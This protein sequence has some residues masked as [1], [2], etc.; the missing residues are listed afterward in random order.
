[1][2]LFD[3]HLCLLAFDCCTKQI[4]LFLIAKLSIYANKCII[5][6][7]DGAYMLERLIY[8]HVSILLTDAFVM[9]WKPQL[10][11]LMTSL[12]IWLFFLRFRWQPHLVIC[13]FIRI[14]FPWY[15]CNET[16]VSYDV[17]HEPRRDSYFFTSQFKSCPFSFVFYLGNPSISA[18]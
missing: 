16:Y 11:S 3:V 8:V 12:V 1:M 4:Y 15:M 6:F 5:F 7:W 13:L 18:S 9:Q 10:R 14:N 2:F 17:N